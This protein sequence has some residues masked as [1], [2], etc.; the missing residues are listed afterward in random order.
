MTTAAANAVGPAL[1]RNRRDQ[2][3]IMSKRVKVGR[4]G[5]RLRL[6]MN[7]TSHPEPIAVILTGDDPIDDSLLGRIICLD[8]NPPIPS[9]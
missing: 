2:K 1:A 4:S 6:E 3:R 8:R 7:T 5:P 9:G